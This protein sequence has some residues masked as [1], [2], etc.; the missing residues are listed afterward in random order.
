MAKAAGLHAVRAVSW[1]T[2]GRDLLVV[3]T[4]DSSSPC[5]LPLTIC[6]NLACPGNSNVYMYRAQA[7][8]LSQSLRNLQCGAAGVMADEAE[9]DGKQVRLGRAG[10]PANNQTILSS[11]FGRSAA[12]WYYVCRFHLT[13]PYVSRPGHH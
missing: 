12:T 3:T 4:L 2:V 10:P 9:S 6:P 11:S 5:V 7:C 1:P 8:V 13:R